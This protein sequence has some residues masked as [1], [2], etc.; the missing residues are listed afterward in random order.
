MKTK[1]LIFDNNRPS[2]ADYPRFKP[3]AFRKKKLQIVT[4]G[5]YIIGRDGYFMIVTHGNDKWFFEDDFVSSINKPF[6]RAKYLGNEDDSIEYANQIRLATQEEIDKAL[7]Y[8]RSDF[9]T[10]N[11]G[12]LL[13]I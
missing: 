6:L 11:N 7:L 10:T 4:E 3:A 8:K 2:S 5:D 13:L 1:Q 9:K 12:Q